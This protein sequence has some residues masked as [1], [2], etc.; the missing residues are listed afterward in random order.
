MSRYLIIFY[1]IFFE[2]GF[3][4]NSYAFTKSDKIDVLHQILDIQSTH[5]N[6]DNKEIHAIIESLINSIN[7]KK[8]IPKLSLRIYQRTL[9]NQLELQKHDPDNDTIQIIVDAL[10]RQILRVNLKYRKNLR[11]FINDEETFQKFVKSTK[12]KIPQCDSSHANLIDGSSLSEILKKIASQ[13][14][15]NETPSLAFEDSLKIKEDRVKNIFQ[16]RGYHVSSFN[17]RWIRKNYSTIGNPRLN[18]PVKK[19]IQYWNKGDGDCALHGMNKN[20]INFVKL[21]KDKFRKDPLLRTDL[22]DGVYNYCIHNHQ[23]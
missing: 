6:K 23:H 8:N 9:E 16:N 1:L 4:I 21:I 13:V 10:I 5:Q 2:F 7:N 11:N 20:R 17:D 14:E 18:E 15:K 3:S 12:P 19:F 22:R